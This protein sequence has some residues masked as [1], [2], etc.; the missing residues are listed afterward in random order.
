[1]SRSE[2]GSVTAE[3]A[4]ALPAIVI[5][6]AVCLGGLALA[7]QYVR[8][9]DAAAAA[10]RDAGRGDGVGVVS[11]LVPG[12]AAEQWSEGHL[13]CVRVTAVGRLAS[14]A[15]PLSAMSCSLGGGQ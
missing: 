13:V 1:M 12:A 3:F 5:V 14:V 7:A 8:V 15:V 9:Q 11:R 10:A 4:V 2:R 6:L